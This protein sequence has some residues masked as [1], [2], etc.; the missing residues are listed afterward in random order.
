VGAPVNG[1]VELAGPEVFRFDE[2]AQRILRAS[3]DPRQVIGDRT[4]RYFGAELHEGSLIPGDNP[5]LAPTRFEDWLSES[6]AEHANLAT[7][8]RAS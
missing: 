5:H 1:V 2:L 7:Q 3:N 4:A 8:R 6:T